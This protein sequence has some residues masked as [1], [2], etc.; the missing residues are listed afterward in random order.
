[1]SDNSRVSRVKVV[2]AL[3]GLIGAGIASVALY[4]HVV[5]TGGFAT[6]P[7][8]CN[9][10]QHINCDK[11]SASE[12]SSFFGVPVASYG[13]F[14]FLSLSALLMVSGERRLVSTRT[15]LAVSL[16]GGV[17]ASL[18]SVA[19]F[20]ISE[21]VIGALCLICLGLYLVSFLVLGIVWGGSFWGE[22]GR[23]FGEGS[24][25]LAGFVVSVVGRGRGAR[26]ARLGAVGLVVFGGVCVYL[27]HAIHDVLAANRPPVVANDPVSMW[28]SAPQVEIR[29]T[30]GT[31]SFDDFVKGD[32]E[33]P[34]EIVEFA[35]IEC[36]ACRA[37]YGGMKSLLTRFEGKYRFIFRHYPLDAQCNPLITREMHRS[38]CLGAFFT[39]CAAE[40]GKFWEALDLVFTDPIFEDEPLSSDVRDFLITKGADALTL[41]RDAVKECLDSGRY[42]RKISEDIEEGTRL[43]LKGTPSVWINGRKVD[44]P[45]VGALEMILRD[46]ERSR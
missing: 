43:G 9:I 6:Q 23:G 20:L 13:I 8:F 38:A 42:Q 35:D 41:D 27:P 45:S 10:S 28:R 37:L 21:F 34:I 32:P 14:F 11:V 22:F 4:H 29:S 44:R 5:Q 1:M 3:V 26:E 2:T 25:A 7:S 31:G 18:S 36:P 17:I 46:A 12:W 15:A 33:A 39:R 30:I 16:V 40:Q 24:R 19:L